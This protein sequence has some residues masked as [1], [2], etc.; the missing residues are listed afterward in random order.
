M[1]LLPLLIFLLPGPSCTVAQSRQ[2]RA[3]IIDSYEIEEGHPG[4]F[5]YVLGKVTIDRKYQVL[6]D[7][8]GQGVDKDP[9]GVL[10]IEESTGRILAYGP[11]DFEE[12]QV[13]KLSFAAKKPEDHS[14]D[15]Q[16]G[17]EI[18]IRDI[19]DNPPLF[20]EPLYEVTVDEALSQGS[21]LL[22]VLAF[23]RDKPNTRNSTFH[24]AIKSVSPESSNIEFILEETGAL[25]F[26]GCFDHEVASKHT[27]VIEAIDHGEVVQLSSS[28][29]AIIYVEDGNDHLPVIT[30]QSGSGKV[31]ENEFGVSPLRL[32]V[33]DKDMTQSKAWRAKY[34]IQGDKGG[35]FKIETNAETN[36][37]ILTVVKPL[38][39]E[40]GA[41]R[42]LKISVENEAPYFS[43]KVKRRPSAGLWD[44]DFTEEQIGGKNI[45]H[46]TTTVV[47]EVEDV[48]DPPNFV[49]TVKEATLKE[50]APIGTWLETVT[51]VDRDATASRD[52]I[53]KVGHDPAGW[54]NIN[55]QT[56]NITTRK[57]VDRESVH[58]VNGV[59]TLM[60]HAVDKGE[61]PMTGTATLQIHLIDVNDNVPKLDVNH[62][63][64][65][66]S[67]GQTPTN[68]SANDLDGAPYGGPFNFELLGN[69]KRRWKLDPSYG[70]TAGLV[71]DSS[72]P[73][74]LYT[75]RVKV[76]DMQGTYGIYWLNATVCSCSVVR[77]CR[78]R[79]SGTISSYGAAGIALVAVALFLLALL[80]AFHISCKTVFIPAYV[81]SEV[82]GILV[83]SNTEAPG[84]EIE[85]GE[86]PLHAQ[87]ENLRFTQDNRKG[88]RDSFKS[89]DSLR[90]GT[91]TISR[92]SKHWIKTE[93]R[94]NALRQTGNLSRVYLASPS[95]QSL[96]MSTSTP[97]Y[98]TRDNG[99][100]I[101][102][103]W[104][105][106]FKARINYQTIYEALLLY[107][108][109][110]LSS[111]Q[112]PMAELLDY[113]PHLYAEEGE[114]NSP[115]DLDY[116]DIPDEHGSLHEV[117]ENLGPQFSE[118]AACVLQITTT[119][120]RTTFTQHR[121]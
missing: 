22:T 88:R 17:V 30:G 10:R 92:S 42:E 89:N 66:M 90:Y 45:Q 40:N 25:S 63:D 71:R 50:D 35:Y 36:D 107:L 53:Y 11:V 34:T 86:L 85:L 120:T 105:E 12:Y 108:Q 33:M 87:S 103:G 95:K 55:P 60:L 6:F 9:K 43:C 91:R 27:L 58:V 75:L 79:N 5:P 52:F 41:M 118:L 38:D 54:M 109:R 84:S 1:L 74:G 23:D 59:Y 28:T 56:G 101:M 46:N 51:A 77:H 32:H 102:D 18:A 106:E 116:L 57:M 80:A 24:Y 29:T 2:K 16:L 44:V 4:P 70:F 72:V 117:L 97:F 64:V 7:L 121:V 49:V 13:L 100:Q 83:T 119:G 69:V 8:K 47:I 113:E 81:D 48:N 19:N 21:H 112:E 61:P 68:I 114:P 94:N 37:G 15:T 82:N 96:E 104:K 111:F 110:R 78:N 39:F 65:C 62:V 26:K 73:G 14:I 31:K 99:V 3:W 115:A 98:P 67:D 20:E 76:S 93:E